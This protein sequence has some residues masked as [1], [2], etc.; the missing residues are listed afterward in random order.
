[1]SLHQWNVL[2]MPAATSTLPKSLLQHE[3]PWVQHPFVRCAEYSIPH[4]TAYFSRA[5]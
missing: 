5:P 2:R 1:M 3:V 4:Y